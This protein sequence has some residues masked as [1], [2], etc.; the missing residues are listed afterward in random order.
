LFCVLACGK[1]HDAPGTGSAAG[2]AGS[3]GSA[4]PVA[5]AGDITV[6]VDRHPLVVE[7]AFVKRLPDGRLQLYLGR[8]GSCAQLLSS[9]FDVASPHVLIDL[10]T[11]LLSDGSELVGGGDVYAGGPAVR[12]EQTKATVSGELTAGTKVSIG[13][14]IASTEAKLDV[15][16]SVTAEMCGDEDAP[17]APDAGAATMTIAGKAVPIRAAVKRG[18]DL[19]LVDLPRDCV[20]AKY[21][22]VRLRREHGT[23][24]LDGRRIPVEL[25]GPAPALRVAP[26]PVRASPPP[27]HT[28][29]N[30]S[31]TDKIGAY[32]V[33]LA[34]L[35]EV[36]DC[37]APK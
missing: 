2:S 35:V 18:D 17:R 6:T 4:V 34:G 37:S 20:A 24:H 25:S 31:G 30:L 13:L 26:A 16:G 9:T 28:L 32:D 19:E 21:T 14:T 8:G 33:A 5:T 3:A 12:S 15:R 22:G 27:G 10:R 1:S 7:H 11:F 29:M 23:W 36:T